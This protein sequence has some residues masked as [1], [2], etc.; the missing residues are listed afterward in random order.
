ML[1]RSGE[2]IR[3]RG[4]VQ[5]VGFRPFVASLATS[6]EISGRVWN[7]GEGVMIH[8]WGSIEQ[9]NHFRKQI[10]AASPPL[11]RIESVEIES[12]SGSCEN[13]GFEITGSTVGETQT[14]VAAD[15]ALCPE[16]LK[17]L[18]NPVDRRYRY[19][20]I[21]CTHCGPRLS[22]IK[23][24]P[25][26][27]ANTSMAAFTM[28][29]ACQAEYDDPT[30]RRFHA[31]PNACPECG[32]RLWLE[33]SGEEACDSGDA[34]RL[35][36]E[37]IR[38]GEIVAIKGI[39]GFHLAC[40]A[41]SESAVSQLRQRKR[42]YQKPFA[43]M[44][45]DIEQVA[46]YACL[47]E[48]EQGLL[49]S[50]EAPI[51]L[52]GQKSEIDIAASV[53]PMMNSLGFMLPYTP[54][55]HLLMRELDSP[56]VMTS[57]NVSDEPQCIDNSDATSKLKEIADL[58][59]LHDREIVN[60]LD[61]AVVRVM[62]DK[63]RVLRCGRG[64]APGSIRLP[65][66]FEGVGSVL[67]MGGELKNSFCM[68]TG[69]HAVLSQHMGDLESGDTL[70][71]YYHNLE[72]YRELYNFEPEQ[73]AVDMH[74]DY[75]SSRHGRELATGECCELV[76]VQHHHAH[77]AAVMAEHGLELAEKVLGV[78]FDGLG[79]GESK[80]GR[81]LWGGEFLLAGYT[82]YERLGS[83]QRLP[84]IGGA[85]AIHEPWRSAYA[86]LRTLGWSDIQNQFSGLD[87][88]S[89]L[90]SR[91]LTNLDRM[92]DQQINAPQASS[93]GRLFDAVA[94][95]VGICRD[96]AAFEGQAAIELEV[97]ASRAFDSEADCGYPVSVIDEG[98]VMR[99]NWQ[100]M[101]MALL[102][103]LASGISN[104]SIAAR[105]H[106]GLIHAVADLA[107]ELAEW[108]GVGK[109]VLSGGVFQNALLLEG[110]ISR[111]SES[112]FE[113]LTAE[114]FPANDGGL[115]LGQAVVAAATGQQ[116]VG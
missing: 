39:G 96:R 89:D 17:E 110:V 4:T 33:Q 55:H 74:P 30:D 97:V 75:L 68:I 49:E 34:I 18:L 24:V 57:G 8:A 84:M 32:P 111:L 14:G 87:I 98:G 73:I 106:H 6:Y 91:P 7:D 45:A 99:L 65:R 101:W 9:L 95:A 52:L 41:R 26:D 85:K 27:R 102:G 86:H 19:P 51:V 109:I 66:G 114:R 104:E 2:A 94:A 112:R 50:V 44:A 21:N 54:I 31:Q 92:I 56:V 38:A 72:L 82:G 35:A 62:G 63:P 90:S 107:R 22:I 1:E 47:T 12:L 42:R 37:A 113:L 80:E 77:I 76:E 61:D 108:H 69:D 79:M 64:F 103:D 67:A 25:Y 83:V 78:A 100:P 3:V 59:L 88:L 11:A 105:F 29:P 58:F 13:D 46:K 53:A 23:A 70:R 81:E 10:E 16:C 36:A 60:R 48:R 40:D 5:G 71:D 116:R 28:C 15:A 20:F 115:S 93:V 43:L